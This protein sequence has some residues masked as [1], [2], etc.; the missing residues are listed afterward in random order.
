MA[1]LGSALG[2]GPRGRRFKSCHSDQMKIIRTFSYLEKRSD[3]LFYLSILTLIVRNENSR[4]HSLLTMVSTFYATDY[5]S[6]IFNQV[7]SIC[8][9]G[10]RAMKKQVILPIETKIH[11]TSFHAQSFLISR[12]RTKLFCGEVFV[13]CWF[14]I[15]WEFCGSISFA[16]S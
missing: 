13:L 14:K 4:Y 9:R 3:Y 5:C 16:T 15:I 8:K 12:K 1:Q 7:R 2:S 6:A 10:S 11:T